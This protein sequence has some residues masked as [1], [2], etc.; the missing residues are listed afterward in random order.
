M[1]Q[2]SDPGVYIQEISSGVRTIT[3]VGTSIAAFVGFF[4]DGPINTAVQIFGMTDFG[5]IVGGLD[6]RSEASYAI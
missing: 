2:A 5:R 6:S 3:S 1:P 4:K